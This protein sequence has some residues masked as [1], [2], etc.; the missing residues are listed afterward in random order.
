M[1]TTAVGRDFCA[2]MM[3]NAFLS[4][5]LTLKK[6]EATQ[7]T[8]VAMRRKAMCWRMAARQAPKISPPSLARSWCLELLR[9]SHTIQMT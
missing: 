9:V 7:M 5:S 1:M 2:D 6:N 4:A 8:I 3:I